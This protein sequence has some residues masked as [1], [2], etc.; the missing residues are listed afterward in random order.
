MRA[1]T[2]ITYLQS[3]TTLAT[4]LKIVIQV[5]TNELIYVQDL[6]RFGLS[7]KVGKEN[8]QYCNNLKPANNHVGS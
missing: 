6:T 1:H 7:P 8:I 2:I 3:T 5:A 4:F